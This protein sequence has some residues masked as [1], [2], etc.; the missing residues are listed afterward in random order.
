MYEWAISRGLVVGLT[1]GIAM[2][3]YD[4]GPPPSWYSYHIQHIHS[5]GVWYT[6]YVGSGHMVA[7]K[8]CYSMLLG[9]MCHSLEY[10]RDY[11][12]MV[13]V[14]D[15]FRV[16]CSSILHVSKEI[17][18]LLMLLAVIRMWSHCVIQRGRGDPTVTVG[19]SLGKAIIHHDMLWL[20]PPTWFSAQIVMVC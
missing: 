3:C 10:I 20:A 15:H 7:A 13:E 2:V 9:T 5:K 14:G 12:D 16:D 1:L 17:K 4:W 18:Q 8:H 11:Y 6:L 19:F